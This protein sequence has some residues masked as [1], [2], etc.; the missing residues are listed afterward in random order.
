MTNDSG[1]DVE[2]P[3]KSVH[4]Y[5]GDTFG[6]MYCHCP[7]PTQI[8]KSTEQKNLLTISNP[9]NLPE[10]ADELKIKNTISPNIPSSSDC[11]R[12]FSEL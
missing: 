7:L 3:L 10:A 2:K 1:K 8:G 5:N 4:N 6:M 9:I 12:A 11:N